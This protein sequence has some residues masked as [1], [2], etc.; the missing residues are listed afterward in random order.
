MVAV[1]ASKQAGITPQEHVAGRG[2]SLD[3]QGGDARH[4]RGLWSGP[5]ARA[6]RRVEP[7]SEDADPEGEEPRK[8]QGGGG[9]GLKGLAQYLH[10][11]LVLV[12]QG[13]RVDSRESSTGPWPW[14]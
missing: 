6:D 11:R 10:R 8:Q 12:S 14:P 4:H 13:L 5:V 2:G 1:T 7:D 3:Q 9:D